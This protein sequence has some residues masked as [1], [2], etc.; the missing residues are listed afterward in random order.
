MV[1]AVMWRTGYIAR[2]EGIAVTVSHEQRCVQIK[3]AART[4]IVST[5]AKPSIKDNVAAILGTKVASSL[6]P[7]SASNDKFGISGV[8]SSAVKVGGKTNGHPQFIFLNSRPVDMPKAV[9]VVN[10]TYRCA[11]N[12]PHNKRSR[13]L[14]FRA[15]VL[16][17]V[18]RTTCSPMRLWHVGARMLL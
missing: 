1:G 15:S 12:L 4:T 10:D 6:E 9:R 14:C 8:I 3:K 17:S 18:H 2:Q 7:L 16:T 11:Y 5:Q 13:S